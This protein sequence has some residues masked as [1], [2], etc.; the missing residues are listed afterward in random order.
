MATK[1]DREDKVQ[2]KKMM[3]FEEYIELLKKDDIIK[4]YRT[5]HS[6]YYLVY[7]PIMMMIPRWHGKSAYYN[8]I[9]KYI[10]EMK[11]LINKK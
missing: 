2:E 5:A 1:R 7:Q 10:D 11:E 3:S 8:F 4:Q 6:L 9:D